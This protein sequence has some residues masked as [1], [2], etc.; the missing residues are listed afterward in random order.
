MK[1]QLPA[2][3]KRL[4]TDPEYF[5]KV[6]AHTFTLSLRPG[7]RTLELEPALSYWQAFIP[8]ALASN[9]S[10]LSS[11]SSKSSPSTGPPAFSKSDL[12]LWCEFMKEKGKAVSKDTWLL[13]IDFLRGVDKDFK[14]HDE[15]AAWPSTIDAF[16]EYARE[17]KASA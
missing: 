10:A 12:D 4:V 11:T 3:R 9:P 8:P 1:S 17:K 5:K 15:E 16:V 14:E 6:Y 13:F 7:A 2:L